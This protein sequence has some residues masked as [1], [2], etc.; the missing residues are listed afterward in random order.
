MAHDLVPSVVLALLAFVAFAGLAGW[1]AAKP[2][3]AATAVFGLIV[4]D[5]AN[6]PIAFKYGLWLYPSDLLFA[7][8][9]VACLIRFSL[10]ATNKTVPRAWWIIGAVQLMLGAWGWFVYGT[11]AG[12]DFRGHFYLW[13]AVTYFC[14]VEWTDRMVDRVVN[15]LVV[16]SACL[17]LLVYYRWVR[18]AVDPAYAQEMMALDTTGVRFRVIGSGPTLVIAIG[19]LSLLFKMLAG[20]LSLLPRLLMPLLLL[21]VVALQ[22]RSVWASVLVGTACLVWTQQG[23]ARGSRTVLTVALLLIP[24]AIAFVL[25]SEGNSVMASIK[26]SAG[27]AVSTEE[28]TMVS[29]VAN[30]EELLSKWAGSKSPVTYLIGRPYG[31][32]FNPVET[33]DESAAF[34][35]VPHN[36]FVHILYRGGLIGL[37]ATLWVFYR[38]WRNAGR[39]TKQGRRRWAPYLFTVLSACFVYYIP[40]WASYES[41][42][43]IGIAISYLGAEKQRK[44]A[45]ANRA[46]VTGFARR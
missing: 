32:G 35:M 39:Q 14:T 21:T 40:Y 36:H 42:M 10:F 45:L 6:L 3:H 19:F 33:E 9:A 5:T 29:R 44:V 31:S 43:L 25:P 24:L 8:F 22:H 17:C 12:V 28:G 26:S 7:V 30:W 38:V 46:M 34:D 11:P 16:C 27:R 23:A 13:V 20:Q 1:I 2:L 41:G 15:A 37:C 18:S 4:L